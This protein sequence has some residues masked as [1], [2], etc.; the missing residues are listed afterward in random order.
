ML[1]LACEGLNITREQLHQELIEGG[2]LFD[3]VSGALTPTALRLTA[4]T[5]A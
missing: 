3:L 1:E 5:L 2:D 4:K